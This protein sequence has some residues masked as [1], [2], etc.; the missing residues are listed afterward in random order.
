MTDQLALPF[1]AQPPEPDLAS[2]S[3]PRVDSESS[4]APEPAPTLVASLA[5]VASRQ[6]F[7]RKLLIGTTRGE[8][9][10][11]L[12]SLARTGTPWLGFE[13]M[14]LRPLAVEVVAEP[15]HERGLRILD[16][17]Q[18]TALIDEAIDVVLAR[19]SSRFA[20]LSDAVGFRKAIEGA[21]QALRMAGISPEVLRRTPFDDRQK[22]EV[23]AK[24]LEL[25]EAGLEERREVDTAGLFAV[26][27]DRL[28]EAPVDRLAAVT[29]VLLPG[30][31]ARGHAGRFVSALQARGAHFL[32]DDRVVG[33]DP[34]P[35]VFAG[36]AGPATHGSYLGS[37]GEAPS[38]SDLAIDVFAA[39]TVTA[40]LREVL[41]RVAAQ[42]IPWDQ[43]EIL[44]PD[45]RTYGS[46]FHAL[47]ES[48]GIPVTF[49]MGLPVERTRP[50]RACAEYFRWIDS[51]F[52][53][54]V[55]RGLLEAGDLRPPEEFDWLSPME[56]T[57]RFRELRIGWG[58]ARHRKRLERRIASLERMEPTRHES[59]EHMER[60]RTRLQ[61]ELEALHAILDPVLAALPEG[62]PDP[63]AGPADGPVSPS[64]V[65]RAT[66]EFLHHIPA[67]D[68]VDETAL[69]S[70]RSV[71]ERIER[72]WHRKTDY[73]AAAAIVRSALRLNVSAPRSE[74]RAP[75]SS[76]PGHV[77]F[78]DLEYGGLANRPHTFVV[79]MDA[80]RFPG[81]G[82]QDPLLLDRERDRLS[83]HDL[84]TSS[85]TLT[86]KV[87]AFHRT[88]ARMRGS[89]TVSYAT[90]EPAEAREL[91]PSAEALAAFR[92]S[93]R[94]PTLSFDAL[95]TFVG[96]P[97]GALPQGKDSL[98]GRD[99]WLAAINEGGRLLD[100]RSLVSESFPGIQRGSEALA[101]PHQ[102]EPTSHIGC[103]RPRPILDPRSSLETVLSASRLEHL[104]TCPRRY[105][106]SSVLKLRPPD[107]PDYRAERWLS[108]LAR[109]DV[110][111]RVFEATLRRGREDP[112]TPLEQHAD[113][114]LRRE[115]ARATELHPTPSRE[116]QERERASLREDVRSFLRLIE[117]RGAKWIE[118]ELKFGFDDV[119]A[120]T[121]RLL[122]EGE[123]R[124]RGAIDRLD[125]APEGGPTVVVDYKTGSAY[126]ADRDTGLFHGGRRLQN[127]LYTMAVHDLLDRPVARM[128]YQYATQRARNSV[129][130][131]EA[132]Q[133][134]AGPFVVGRMM[135]GVAAGHFVPT[136]DPQ[137]CKWCDFSAVCRVR[138]QGN[139][140]RSPAADWTARWMRR[141]E[142]EPNALPEA[143]RELRDVRR[144]DAP[145]LLPPPLWSGGGDE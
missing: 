123:V 46:A 32:A 111:H 7:G 114:A 8:G 42:G 130:A 139:S 134:R 73:R 86:E 112:E 54:E 36:R 85:R 106:Y 24:T 109:G 44:T 133:L 92:L 18:V 80:G 47:V 98:D 77:Y 103:V 74:G 19:R 43:V 51:G 12:R 142:S 104:G 31:S 64:E 87:F 108:P 107:D 93:R 79:G 143:L 2:E 68:G 34:P 15:L 17:Y 137:D 72:S 144:E 4:E 1:D 78:A 55:V 9:R 120:A 53:A 113:K 6:S 40:E 135:D 138:T 140:L 82:L 65:A 50:G 21:V 57:R 76:T 69:H 125:G 119:E 129:L 29:V 118:L 41:R 62:V 59:R 83:P 58:R 88:F 67:R 145:A 37:P 25:F 117:E 22:R 49:G 90:W 5:E 20:E 126:N 56:L 11:L 14:T 132:D 141:A 45:S 75:W 70:L 30:L 128:E 84:P 39:T 16:R 52:S 33:V 3:A 97:I 99:V 100:G 27:A 115:L 23:I 81:S 91:S 136:D 95:R 105:L 10:E 102:E 38:D 110:L 66:L 121:I 94:D 131:F 122:P 116:I 13:A 124:L 28:E 61:A 48:L 60:R 63:S 35:D 127:V 96:R 71:L 101:A 26:A 89:V